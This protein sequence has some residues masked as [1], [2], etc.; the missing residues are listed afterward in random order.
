MK[1]LKSIG[2]YFSIVM[3]IMLFLTG[4][5]CLAETQAAAPKLKDIIEVDSKQSTAA[6]VVT[7]SGKKKLIKVGPDDEFE[8]GVPRTAVAGYIRAVKDNDLETAAQYLDLRNLPAGY[9]RSQGPELAKQLKV[10]LDRALWVDLDLL[11]TD[12]KGHSDDGL[13]SYRDLV[14]QIDIG[15]RTVDILLQRVPRGDGIYIWKFSTRTVRD[16]PTLNSAFGYGLIGEKLSRVFPSITILGLEIWQW[17]FLFMIIFAIALMVYP[18]VRLFAWLVQRKNDSSF[19]KMVDKFIRGPLYL[20]VIVIVTRQNFDLIHPSLTAKALIEA[21]T[22]AVFMSTWILVSVVGLV[23]EFWVQRLENTGRENVLALLRPAG[24]AVKILIVFVGLLIWLDNIGFSITT[25][26]AGLGIGGIA[27]ALATQKS[28]EDFIG[29]MTLYLAAPVKVGDFCRFGDKMGV[30]EDIGLRATKVRTLEETV[31]SIPNAEF[32]SIQI[33]NLTERKRYRFNPN[34][35]LAIDTSPD[36]IRFILIELKKLLH[37]HQMVSE[38]PLRVSFIGIEKHSLDIE[39]HCYIKTTDINDFKGVAE[40]LN[41]RF[42]DIVKQAGA[43]IAIQSK[44]EY[45]GHFIESDT[46]AKKVAEEQI[47]NLRKNGELSTELTEEERVNLSGSISYP[48]G[49][50]KNSMAR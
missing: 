27:L 3:T 47:N 31:I 11:S 2:L 17:V 44:I 36:Q 25:V 49:S 18:F 12:P 50:A 21:G 15:H 22:I 16:I 38:S 46:E 32:S 13:P 45:R 26:L 39:I 34:I 5:R 48:P 28:I 6:E 8:R 10:V 29:A 43:T 30:V 14:G 4:T 40:D 7:E 41:L 42:M 37:A 9:T 35:P 1:I 33:E 24:T 23:R 20:A 19:G